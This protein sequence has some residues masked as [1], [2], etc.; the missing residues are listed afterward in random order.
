MSTD[1]IGTGLANET[2]FSSVFVLT[3]PNIPIFT[4]NYV[5][6]LNCVHSFSTLSELLLYSPCYLKLG[7][8]IQ[9]ERKLILLDSGDN[10]GLTIFYTS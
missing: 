2:S 6:D 10:L 5:L 7:S 4:L 1:L 9:F 8:K 3:L